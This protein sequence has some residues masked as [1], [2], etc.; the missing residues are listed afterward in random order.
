MTMRGGWVG[1]SARVYVRW[2]AG[3]GVYIYMCMCSC[4]CVY[5]L[6]ITRRLK[7]PHFR[8][9]VTCRRWMPPDFK[10]EIEQISCSYIFRLLSLCGGRRC[11]ITS[12]FWIFESYRKSPTGTFPLIMFTNA[13]RHQFNGCVQTSVQ[14]IRID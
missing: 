14:Q 7:F 11:L 1:V 6:Q 4:L 12:R 3:G 9:S 2:W 5:V 10:A 13:Y 8:R